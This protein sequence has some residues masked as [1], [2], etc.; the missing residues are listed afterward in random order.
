[1]AND[2]NATDQ[3]LCVDVGSTFTKAALVDV[4]AGRLV[5]TASHATTLTTDV[6]GGVGECVEDLTAGARTSWAA[7]PLL[8]SSAG[9]GLR[10]AVVGNEQL[11]T[12]EAGRRVALSSGGH[13]VAVLAGGLDAAA[14]TALRESVPDVVLLAGG[15]DG[16]NTEVVLASARELAGWPGPVVVAGNS[17]AMPEAV[18]VLE[19]AGTP[20]VAAGNVMPRIGVLEPDSARAAIRQ[21]FLSHV[22]G[23]KHL[24]AGSDFQRLVRGATP[25]VVLRAV[26]LLA[27]GPAGKEGVGG[28]VLVDVGGATTDVYSVVEPVREDDADVRGSQLSRDVLGTPTVSRTVEGDLGV[29]WSAP[30][31][32]AAAFEAGWVDD[33]A[34]AVAAAARRQDRPGFVP[35]DE[36][37][38]DMDVRLAAWALGLA[39]RRHA[40]RARARYEATG[41]SRG[42]WVERPGVDLREVGLVVGSGGVLRHAVRRD[43]ALAGRFVAHL[44]GAGGWQVPRRAGFTVDTDYCWAAAGLIADEHPDAAWSLLASLIPAEPPASL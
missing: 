20:C 17:A 29:R 26:E 15:T 34:G 13:V 1:V 24:S 37:E 7:D 10:I 19:A 42:R 11:V 41:P 22:I 16:G 12:A 6:M 35:T 38:L 9:G 25:D 28:L 32:V 14:M 40:G 43:P 8:C 5:A 33:P 2:P 36:A 3:V 23:G 18:S 30:G 27:R 21:M 39:V 4:T 44:D 31:T